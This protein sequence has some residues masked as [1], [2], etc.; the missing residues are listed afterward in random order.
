MPQLTHG[1]ILFGA[2]IFAGILNVTA[3]GGSMLTVPILIFLGVNPLVANGTNRIGIVVQ[4]TF[5]VGSFK[6]HNQMDTKSSL[7]LAVVAVP[8]ALIG[9]FV[10]AHVSSHAFKV[11]LPAVLLFS[12]MALF[13][14]LQRFE[15]WHDSRWKSAIS[16]LV[17]FLIGFYGGFIQIGVGFLF[18]A[19]L[20]TLFS[21]NLVRTNSHKV[22]IILLYTI[23]AL[24]IFALSGEVEW[25][26]GLILAAGTAV[27]AII[28]TRITVK[29]GDKWIRWIA[30]TAVLAITTKLVIDL[31][32]V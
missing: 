2:G 1:F 13:L 3:G 20:R 30:A 23:P 28:G 17:L 8:G 29:G 5:A 31:A 11:I 12:G 14:P 32:G 6:L 25:L 15:G 9:A 21:M 24:I 26:L 4:N 16:V 10:A 7:K 22:M 27:G 18:M 19:G